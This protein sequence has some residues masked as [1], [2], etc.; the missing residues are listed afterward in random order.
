MPRTEEQFHEIREKTKTQILNSSLKLFAEKG[1][2]GTSIS[3][4]A[5]DANISKGLIYNYFESKA[6]I[7]ESI[8]KKLLSEFMQF[9]EPIKTNSDPSEKL[10]SILTETIN[11]TKKNKDIWKLYLGFML[12]PVPVAFE[13]VFS[14]KLFQ[15]FFMEFAEIFKAAGVKD[16]ISEAYQFGAIM[17][18]MQMHYIFMDD[19]YPIDK[20]EKF[21]LRKYSKEELEKRK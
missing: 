16:P 21:I 4:I 13:Q 20:M 1:F 18:G 7:A 8:Y 17:D 14:P 19:I 9:F 3:D 11:Y 2:N 6:A 5:E 12:Q 10:Q 15:N